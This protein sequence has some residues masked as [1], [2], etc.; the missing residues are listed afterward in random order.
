MTL[1]GTGGLLTYA[2]AGVGS[3]EKRFWRLEMKEGGY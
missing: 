3:G 2:H 1:V